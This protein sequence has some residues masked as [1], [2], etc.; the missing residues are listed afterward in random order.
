MLETSPLLKL[1][2]L[3]YQQ[4]TFG[5]YSYGSFRMTFVPSFLTA[6]LNFRIRK[7]GL[8]RKSFWELNDL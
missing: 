2:N 6:Q 3:K 1:D 8:C 5:T 7:F 4:I